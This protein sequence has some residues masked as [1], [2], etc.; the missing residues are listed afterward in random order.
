MKNNESLASFLKLINITTRYLIKNGRL[1]FVVAVGNEWNNRSAHCMAGIQKC[2]FGYSSIKQQKSTF[3]SYNLF[4]D[5]FY[6]KHG[7]CDVN[8]IYFALFTTKTSAQ[9]YV[10]KVK[11]L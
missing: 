10:S 5:V 7:K 6:T 2:A 3:N 4:P 1:I 9:E 8:C 11:K